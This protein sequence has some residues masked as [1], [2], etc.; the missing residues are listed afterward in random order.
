MNE[1]TGSV[2]GNSASTGLTRS[3][4]NMDPA[5]DWV[6][7]TTCE[8]TSTAS[9]DVL[10]SEDVSAYPNPTEGKVSLDL[11]GLN[12]VSIQVYSMDGQLVYS[13]TNIT[14]EEHT[15]NLEGEAGIYHVIIITENVRKHLK[16]IR[17]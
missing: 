15:F 13:E 9:I 7:G 8:S 11:G 4:V 1:G 6:E 17:L 5:T 10:S 2:V 16:L 14:T 12:D 3:L